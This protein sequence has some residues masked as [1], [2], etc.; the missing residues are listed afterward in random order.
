MITLHGPGGVVA[1]GAACAAPPPH[2]T[3]LDLV[4]PNETEIALAEEATGLAVPSREALSEVERSSRLRRRRDALYLSTPMVSF[5]PGDL[6]LR[7][8]G[9]ILT[10]ERLVSI[11]FQPLAAFDTVKQR[12]AEHD[13][14]ETS[15]GVFGALV[16]E[17][18]DAMADSLEAMSDALD[19]LSTR[20]F[21]FDAAQGGQAA[22]KRRDLALRRILGE[23]GR[24]GKALAKLRA[25]LV[26]LDRIV[27]FVASEA[28][29]LKP[30]DHAHLDTLHLDIASLEE[31]ETRLS[32][33]VQ[34]L[35]DAALG[36]INIEQN[37]TFRVLTVVSI[38][39]IPPTLI[40]SMYGMN[41]KHMPELDW[42]WGYPYG[43][44]LILL[45]ALAPAVWFK[46]KGW[47]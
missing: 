16:A 1:E 17:L 3:W 45:S 14:P 7:P 34:F 12:Q 41:F 36:L 29:W 40:A 19:A 38:I 44:G 18:V 2:A 35:L 15:V 13:G 32:E 4:D 26:G 8:L 33:T 28:T 6:S 25:A 37:N 31:F 27:P 10:R 46:A 42:A 23:I 24:R 22:P 5:V 21:H 47:F 9:F 30:E 11:R 20:V 43:L 39:G